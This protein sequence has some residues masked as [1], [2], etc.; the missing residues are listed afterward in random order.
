MDLA[1]NRLGN[2]SRP[3]GSSLEHAVDMGGIAG[4]AFHI[5]ADRAEDRDGEVGQHLFE[6]RELG[7]FEL[8]ENL[9]QGTVDKRRIDTQ[10]VVSF[11]PRL[12]E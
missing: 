8:A 2:L 6:L 10:Q 9:R 11:G 5:R 7:A 12:L 1:E 3:L 4:E